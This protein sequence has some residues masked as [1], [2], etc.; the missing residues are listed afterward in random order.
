MHKVELGPRESEEAWRG[1]PGSE[2]QKLLHNWTVSRVEEL[3]N[4]LEN[5]PVDRVGG[6]QAAIK[7]VRSLNGFLH[8][9]D[10]RSVEEI[11]GRQQN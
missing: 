9:R 3:R 4:Q 2:L 1:F 7:E 11:Y 5:C 10:P 6:I 8:K